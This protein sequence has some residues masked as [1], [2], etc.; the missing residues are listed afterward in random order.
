MLVL[1]RKVGETIDIGNGLVTLCIAG[2]H[3]NKVRIGIEAPR[4]LAVHRSEIVERIAAEGKRA[5][6][7]R[8]LAASATEA[9]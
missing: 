8:P 4:E 3:G 7:P 2:I 9:A 1:S 6:A 5:D